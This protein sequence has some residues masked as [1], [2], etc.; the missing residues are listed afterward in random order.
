MGIETRHRAGAG[1]QVCLAAFTHPER[2]SEAGHGSGELPPA[3][4]NAAGAGRVTPLTDEC[5]QS[6]T[7]T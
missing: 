3:L 1:W 4:L 2:A 6:K 5:H 7:L